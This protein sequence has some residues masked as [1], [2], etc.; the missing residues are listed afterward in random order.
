MWL[1]CRS[2]QI[3][4]VQMCGIWPFLLTMFNSTN[5]FYKNASIV[6]NRITYNIYCIN[7]IY[8][9]LKRSNIPYC[10]FNHL[11][12]DLW[13][14]MMKSTWFWVNKG[15]NQKVLWK[16]KPIYHI[17]EKKITKIKNNLILTFKWPS[18]F[19]SRWCPRGPCEI[20]TTC[21]VSYDNLKSATKKLKMFIFRFQ[22]GGQ[23]FWVTNTSFFFWRC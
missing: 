22:T 12:I 16:R 4:K 5:L 6:N 18:L 13:S 3:S 1:Y 23:T 9:L 10:L 20:H 15:Q 8:L 19:H 11:F 7:E 2:F 17:E 14:L 21:E